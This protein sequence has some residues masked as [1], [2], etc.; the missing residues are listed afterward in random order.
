[1]PNT[2][3][4]TVTNPE[5]LF[6]RAQMNTTNPFN[7]W[8]KMSN[9]ESFTIYQTY[10]IGAQIWGRLTD[11]PGNVSQE[12]A[13][14]QIANKQFARLEAPPADIPAGG[15]RVWMLALDTWARSQGFN[16][17]PPP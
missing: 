12:Y 13:C 3:S 2:L 5:G 11:N 1:M 16:G 10:P 15:S 14:L 8:R 4:Y 17:P 6:V 9:G 7:I